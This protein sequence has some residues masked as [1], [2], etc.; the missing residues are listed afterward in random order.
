MKYSGLYFIS[1][2]STNIDASLSI[3]NTL[4]QS[5]ESSF[6]SA[7]RQAPWSLSYRAFRD[8]IPPGYQHP[9]GADGKPKPYAHSYQHLLH[10]SNLDSN[11]TYIYA[12][13][14]T[15][16]ETVVS[17]PL[18]QQDAYGSIGE[19]RATREGPQ[20]ASVLSPGI[21]VCITT[22]VGA[23]DTDD[24][25]DSG[26]ASVGNETTMQVDGDDDE[27]DFEYAQTV[28][29]EFWS[30]IKDGR[31]LGRSEVREVMMAPVAPRKKA[32]ERDAAVRRV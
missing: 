8:T 24:G 23:E 5:I 20:S 13:P 30:K 14:A 27:I 17:I 3:V 15:Q 22:T 32:Q 2:P 4:I 9:T 16:P 1:N 21:V 25:P 29:R 6:Q 10:L 7:T 26:H 19:L 18:R 12:Q 31:D 28:I 11:R